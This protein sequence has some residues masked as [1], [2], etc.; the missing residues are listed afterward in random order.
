LYIPP[1][2]NVGMLAQLLTGASY[3]KTQIPEADQQRHLLR[4]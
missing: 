3:V 4:R 2:S 1:G